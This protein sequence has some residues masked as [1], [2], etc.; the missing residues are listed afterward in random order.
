MRALETL[1]PWLDRDEKML[2]EAELVRLAEVLPKS[3]VLQTMVA[4]RH[5]LAAVWGR[6]TASREQLVKQ[7]Q[8]WCRRADASGIQ[9]LVE[10]SQR[11][12]SY[13]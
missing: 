5:E 3:R 7:L 8:D 12:R 10:F 4:M 9:P 6:S 11:L 13:A 2:R 1:K